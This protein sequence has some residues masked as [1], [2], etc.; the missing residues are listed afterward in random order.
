VLPELTDEWAGDVAG[1]ESA[2]ALREDVRSRLDRV[3]RM[4]Q[5]VDARDK[6]LEALL[7]Q[8]DVPLPESVVENELTFRRSTTEQQLT[9]GGLT[10]EGYLESEGKTSEEF[11]AELAEGAAAA[12]KAQLVLDA[13]ADA[14]EVGI[15]DAELS[16]QVVRRAQRAG[17]SPEEF[18]QQVVSSGQLPVL[19]SEVRR[20]KALA[21]VMEAATIVDEAGAPVDLEALAEGAGPAPDVEVDDDGRPFHVHDDGAVHYLD[22]Q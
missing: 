17:V 21:T 14:E 7:A 13:V 19:I 15:T 2:D 11:E 12:V 8:V 3:K 1:L 9:Q 22:E 4:Q 18:A 10:L 6:V 20:G 5:G 16:Q